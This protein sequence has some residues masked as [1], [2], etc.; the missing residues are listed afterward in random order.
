MKI[1]IQK[2]KLCTSNLELFVDDICQREYN[3]ESKDWFNALKR[4]DIS[5]FKHLSSL[6]QSEWDRMNNLSINARRILIKHELVLL[7]NDI[8]I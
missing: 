4:E 6:S 2:K 8:N 5:S 3:D 7:M 1:V